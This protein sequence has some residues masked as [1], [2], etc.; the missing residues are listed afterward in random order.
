MLT[1]FTIGKQRPILL[2]VN[3]ITLAINVQSAV[4]FVFSLD[5]LKSARVHV[6]R[7]NNMLDGH[8]SRMFWFLSESSNEIS[9]KCGSRRFSTFCSDFTN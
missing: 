5:L 3:L 2:A 7:I 4:C 1:A 6:T 8:L 9:D